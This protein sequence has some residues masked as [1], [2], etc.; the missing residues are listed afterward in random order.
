MAF[1]PHSLLAGR[2]LSCLGLGLVFCCLVVDCL[3][4]TRSGISWATGRLSGPSRRQSRHLR[5]STKNRQF[6][7]GLPVR[8]LPNW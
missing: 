4:S 1:R 3:A 2:I 7:D 5:T 8:V 6:L